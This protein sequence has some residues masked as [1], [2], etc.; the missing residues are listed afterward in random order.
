MIHTMMDT[1]TP[2]LT[3]LPFFLFHRRMNPA[4]APLRVKIC[5]ISSPEEAR[6]AA[7]AGADLLGLVVYI[8]VLIPVIVAALNALDVDAVTPRQALE[9]LYEL[10]RLAG[11]AR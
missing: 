2:A 8:L 11:T 7:H 4:P 1:S 3:A 6:M 5:C 10:A 9:H